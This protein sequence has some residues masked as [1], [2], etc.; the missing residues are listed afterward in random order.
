MKFNNV[1]VVLKHDFIIVVNLSYIRNL[2]IIN[3]LIMLDYFQ[4]C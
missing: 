1:T 2:I 4:K 3:V